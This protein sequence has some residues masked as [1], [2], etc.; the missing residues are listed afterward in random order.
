MSSLECP[1]GRPGLSPSGYLRLGVRTIVAS[2][3]STVLLIFFVFKDQLEINI[4]WLMFTDSNVQIIFFS[5][6]GVIFVSNLLSSLA[7]S[8]D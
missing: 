5:I 4:G 6:L 2:F 3:T 7:I 8:L 1:E